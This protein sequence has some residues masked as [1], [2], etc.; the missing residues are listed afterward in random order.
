MFRIDSPCSYLFIPYLSVSC[1]ES[2]NVLLGPHF[3]SFLTAYS[4]LVYSVSRIART[5]RLQMFF[6][7]SVL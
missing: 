4:Q 6:K 3:M 2:L 5:S 7:I 1:F